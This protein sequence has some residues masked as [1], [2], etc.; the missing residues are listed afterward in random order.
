MVLW[1]MKILGCNIYTN[2]RQCPN[3]IIGWH[4]TALQIQFVTPFRNNILLWTNNITRR[5]LSP[6]VVIMAI[7]CHLRGVCLCTALLSPKICPLRKPLK[8]KY[9]HNKNHRKNLFYWSQY[10][11]YSN[12]GLST[13]MG[14]F[15]N[16]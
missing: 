8:I 3:N 7:S 1:V 16:L 13:E 2:V 14:L 12:Y 9:K 5:S 4:F 10:K 6:N 15:T 11:L